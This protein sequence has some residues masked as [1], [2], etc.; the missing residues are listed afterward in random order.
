[1]SNNSSNEGPKSSHTM[2][3]SE[4]NVQYMFVQCTC[5]CSCMYYNFIPLLG[6]L[7]LLESLNLSVTSP[8][9]GIFNLYCAPHLLPFLSMLTAASSPLII[10][11]Q[12]CTSRC[13]WFKYSTNVLMESIFEVLLGSRYIES[14]SCRMPLL[15]TS[16]IISEEQLRHGSIRTLVNN[17]MSN[18]TVI[19]G[20]A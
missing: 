18:D 16:F 7:Q 8:L 4:L 6:C 13:V 20:M 17:E 14:V 1:M 10:Y 9:E 3:R 12:Q 11:L 15:V 2:L 19:M 5:T